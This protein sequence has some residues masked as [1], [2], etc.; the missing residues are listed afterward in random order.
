MT[1][2]APAVRGA[3]ARPPAH[4]RA[5]RA[6]ASSS[7]TARS[8]R[9][10]TPR[11]VVTLGEGAT[12]LVHADAPG[13]GLGP[14]QPPPQVRG[15]EP[16]RLVQGPRAW[17]GRRE[18]ARG[19]RP[20][21]RLRLDRQHVGLGRR[22]RRRRRAGG[23]RR[24]AGRQDRRRQAAPGAGRRGAGRRRRR[25]LRRRPARS[26]ASS[27]SRTSTRSRSSTRSTRTGS[28]ARRRPPSRSATTSAGRRTSWRSR[29]ATPA[30][31]A[32]T[33]S[34]SGRTARPAAIDAL[35]RMW[36]FQ[37]AGAAPIVLGHPVERPETFAT[38]IRIGNPASWATGDR[39][40]RR[41]RRPDRGGHATTRSSAPTATWPGS[42]ASSASRP[43]RRAWPASGSCARRGDSTPDALVVCVLTGHGLK[44]P[45]T[46]PGALG[47]AARRG[48]ADGS[49]RSRDC[50]RLVRTMVDERT[51]PTSTAAGSRSRSRRRARTSGPATTASRSRSRSSTR[52]E[53][54][55]VARPGAG[56]ELAVE[57]EGA[58]ELPAD[59]S[60]RFVRG[61]E[62]GLAAAR[63]EMP[64]GARLADR[65]DEPDPARPRPR[66]VGR[67][68][69][70]RAP[71]RDGCSAGATLDPL[72][73]AGLATELEGH[74][75]N[76][77]AALLGG[78]TRR[79]RRA[80]P[81]TGDP[82]RRRRATCGPSSSSPTCGSPPRAMRAALPAT[83]PL[84]DA[85]ANL[86]RVALGV[87]GLA[88]GRTD[89]LAPPHRGPPPRAVPGGRLPAAPR[90][91]AAARGA[92]ALGACLSGA[93]STV[94]A[95]ADSLALDRPRRGR[96]PCRRRRPRP[97]GPRGAR[98]AAQRG[99]ARGAAARSVATR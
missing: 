25:Q 61:L 3:P 47:R 15:R 74:P 38:A 85:V 52:V 33:G 71:R 67:G 16:D 97:A 4:R 9:S 94:I 50:A 45:D 5:R 30:T 98:R 77:A 80:T 60:N 42:R 34:A 49:A 76:A 35:P 91:V 73:A 99:R 75:D 23:R 96:L 37:A 20:L 12:P 55:V 29:S 46:P 84:A 41:V 83:V 19:G 87:A 48:G 93:G 81:P 32:P 92:G 8:S 10:P 63:G 59:R 68:D 57:G 2:V 1:D 17:C 53:V 7:A 43:R 31:S 95:F 86:G 27:P 70:G 44:D 6:R 26:S 28:R 79:R 64:G 22:L 13:R 58:G 69:R 56:V 78:F 24:P 14:P 82:V 51:S 18:G 72:S 21:D 88:T 66:L 40:P 11:R 39:R 65:D 54:E 89:L 36:G 90:L 62:R